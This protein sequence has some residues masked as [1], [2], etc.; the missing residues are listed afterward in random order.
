MSQVTASMHNEKKNDK[1]WHGSRA[2]L[3]RHSDRVQIIL[4]VWSYLHQA[5]A[6]VGVL[7]LLGSVF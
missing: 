7:S 2:G 6:G 3:D 4:V 1:R 5:A